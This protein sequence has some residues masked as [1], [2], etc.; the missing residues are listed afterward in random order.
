MR[1]F[2]V[3]G[4]QACGCIKYIFPLQT[5]A[6][7]GMQGCIYIHHRF[8]IP[9]VQNHHLVSLDSQCF[10]PMMSQGKYLPRRSGKSTL[11]AWGKSNVSIQ[12]RGII[13]LF[14]RTRSGCK[15]QGRAPPIGNL[16]S[17]HGQVLASGNSADLPLKG[18]LGRQGSW[19]RGLPGQCCLNR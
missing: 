7:D 10:R 14:V 12:R 15:T 11:H 8:Q 4:G 1:P 16:P 2:K 5:R 17:G 18:E 3:L 6:S 9:N 19:P 13:F